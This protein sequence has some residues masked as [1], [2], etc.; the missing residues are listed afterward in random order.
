MR[1]TIAEKDKEIAQLR[2]R[3]VVAAQQEQDR[4][5]ALVH[6]QRENQMHKAAIAHLQRTGKK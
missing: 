6:Y 2:A 1:N 3:L 4:I 5:N